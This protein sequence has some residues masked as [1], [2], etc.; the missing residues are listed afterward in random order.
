VRERYEISVDPQ[1]YFDESG[2]GI[3]RLGK[4]VARDVVTSI[5]E[6]F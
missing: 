2:A 6:K 4:D 5:L 3:E 1:A